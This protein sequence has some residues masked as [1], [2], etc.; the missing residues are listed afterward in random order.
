MLP[1]WLCSKTDQRFAPAIQN[2][3]AETK[4]RRAAVVGLLLGDDDVPQ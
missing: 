4:I 1:S 3:D 2:D